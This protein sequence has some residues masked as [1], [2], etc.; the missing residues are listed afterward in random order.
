[1]VTTLHTI[2]TPKGRWNDTTRSE[3]HATLICKRYFAELECV[4]FYTHA[5]L[6]QLDTPFIKKHSSF[7]SDAQSEKFILHM[8][9]TVSS[10]K[11][12]V[13]AKIQARFLAKQ[14][15]SLH[16]ARASLQRAN[17]RHKRD[18][19]RRIHKYWTRTRTGNNVFID[20]LILVIKALELE[21]AVDGPYRVLG[22]DQHTLFFQRKS[23]LN[24]L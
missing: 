14:Q 21:H 16:R 1:M 20:S 4:H 22:Q 18:F 7:R 3:S 23:S 11:N 10:G 13:A 6:Q 9:H 17:E 24:V 19:E 8:K 12:P 15:Y 5:R 2:H